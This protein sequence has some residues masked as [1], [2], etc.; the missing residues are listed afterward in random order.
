MSSETELYVNILAMISAGAVYVPVNVDEPNDRT[1]LV[2][3]EVGLC[4]VLTG[5]WKV[6]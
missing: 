1:E 2:W 4:P 5:G 6:T 3:A